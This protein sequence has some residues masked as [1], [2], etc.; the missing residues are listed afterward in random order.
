MCIIVVRLRTPYTSCLSVLGAQPLW[1]QV[2]GYGMVPRNQKGLNL[3]QIQ[4]VHKESHPAC[5][6]Q[7]GWVSDECIRMH[8]FCCTNIRDKMQKGL[9]VAGTNMHITTITCT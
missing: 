3:L 2:D 7:A 6:N 4:K 9:K 8:G 5:P 1:E